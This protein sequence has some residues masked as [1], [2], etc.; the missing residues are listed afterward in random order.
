MGDFK[1]LEVWQVAHSLACEVYGATRSFPKT[2]A[3]GLTSQLRR[4]TVSIAA[5]I[6]EGCGRKGDNEFR[7]FLKISQGSAAEV[8]YHLL[9]SRDVGLLED[10]TYA[11]LFTQVGRVQCMLARLTR[12]L[13][14]HRNKLPAD[15]G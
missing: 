10:A 7:R 9:L 1:K 6:A 11:Q 8:E 4:A 15:S 2:E 13:E 3:Y 12:V 14:P 5:N